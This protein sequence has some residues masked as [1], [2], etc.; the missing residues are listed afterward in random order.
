MCRC[1]ISWVVGRP[2]ILF[3]SIL[4]GGEQGWH[5]LLGKRDM[6]DG[7][8]VIEVRY[9][10][11]TDSFAFIIWFFEKNQIISIDSI[12]SSAFMWKTETG[13]SFVF[14]TGSKTPWVRPYAHLSS[15]KPWIGKIFMGR[16]WSHSERKHQTR[17]VRF[18]FLTYMNVIFTCKH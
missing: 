11:Q 16:G 4:V 18:S 6:A 15:V 7:K 12:I 9:F 8:R 17:Y 14:Q 5:C 13:H 2:M 1:K 10:C 3:A